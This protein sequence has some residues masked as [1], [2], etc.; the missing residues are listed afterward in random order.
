MRPCVLARVRAI[1]V[2]AYVFD[3]P[4]SDRT[5]PASRSAK[6]LR[7]CI[8]DKVIATFRRGR[9]DRAQPLDQSHGS[10]V[11]RRVQIKRLGINRTVSDG[12]PLSLWSGR[13]GLG[14]GAGM[15]LEAV[16]QYGD[17]GNGLIVSAS[18]VTL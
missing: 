16:P 4:R 8:A 2:L 15:S 9:E 13:C 18:H 6:R 10:D 1:R 11:R 5:L 12:A 17:A 14:Q 7:Y 3:T